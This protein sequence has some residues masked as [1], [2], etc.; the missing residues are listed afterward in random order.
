MTSN[1]CKTYSAFK[2]TQT[3][4]QKSMGL[5][6]FILSLLEIH[7]VL[8]QMLNF[9]MFVDY[10][11]LSQIHFNSQYESFAFICWLDI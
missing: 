11:I 6:V 10:F 2:D 1:L 7:M 8:C 4:H 3:I 9:L 5:L